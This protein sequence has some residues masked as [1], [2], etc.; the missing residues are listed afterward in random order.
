M[1]SQP[2]SS[3]RLGTTFT[4][5][6]WLLLIALVAW[7]FQDYLTKQF[8]PNQQPQTT[9]SQ[10]KASVV[11]Q[12]NKQG[13]YVVTGLIN[14]QPVTFLL[15]TGATQVSIPATLAERLSLQPQGSYWVQTANGRVKVFS[16]TLNTLSIGPL[17]L[18]NVDA[19]INPAMQG[20][21]IL[22]GMSALKHV[23]FQ[24]SGDQLILREQ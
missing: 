18:Y 2:S 21:T 12:R 10:G 11:L 6:S 1:P 19:N 20:N 4:I 23:E 17:F 24:Q 15:D 16:T 14:Q 22:L 8:N 7:A 3:S 9:V 5:I 13:H